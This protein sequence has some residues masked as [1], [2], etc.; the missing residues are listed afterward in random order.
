[1]PAII[2]EALFVTN[3]ADAAVLRSDKGRQAIALGY[4]QAIRAYF[5]AAPA[6]AASPAKAP[7][8]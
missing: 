1:M 7:P 6:R 3:D 2:G 8:G 5:Q 4:F